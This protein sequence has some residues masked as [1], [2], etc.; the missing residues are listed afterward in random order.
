MFGLLSS[1]GGASVLRSIRHIAARPACVALLLSVLA[2]APASAQDRQDAVRDR[3]DPGEPGERSRAAAAGRAERD[4]DGWAALPLASYS[5]ETHLGLGAFGVYFFRLGDEPAATRPSSVALVGLYSTR[6]QSIVE[7]IP[8]LYWDDERWHL[9]TKI[10]FRNFPDSFWGVG[11]EQPDDNEERYTATSY[12]ARAWLRYR[13]AEELYLGL[14]ADAQHLRVTE[15]ERNGLFDRTRIP[16]EDGGRTVGIGVTAGWDTRDNA[17]DTREGA[18]YQITLMTW[19]PPLG[20]EHAWSRAI[21]DLRQFFDLG[22]TH[23]LG[24]QLYGEINAGEVP[25]YQMAQLG[26]QNLMRGYFEGRYRDAGMLAGQVEWRFPIAWRFRGVVFAGAGDVF[27]HIGDFAEGG[28]EVAGGT[29]LRFS[30]NEQERLNLRVDVGVG[31][32]TWGA[33]LGIAEAF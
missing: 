26:G 16:G 13:I 25:F 4:R 19:Q 5:P 17:V 7:L 9:W 29:G 10:D 12:R 24:V 20:S 6:H 15:T 11:P 21:V 2:P 27:H 14:S 1:P 23:S 32:D 18:L 31:I 3:D 22:G 30:L 33:Y 8:E 28:L